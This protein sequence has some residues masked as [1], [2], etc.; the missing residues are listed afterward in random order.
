MRDRLKIIAFSLTGGKNTIKG[1]WKL[2]ST[3]ISIMS[4]IFAFSVLL[5]DLLGFDKAEMLCKH[6]W[7]CLLLAGIL[8]SLIMNREKVS[9]KGT[10]EGDDLQ[11][12]IEVTDLFHVNASSYVIPTNTFFRT[13]MEGEY[14]SP[15]SVQGAFQLKFFKNNREELDQLILDS[16]LQ[17]G[18]VGE[19]SKDIYG[20]VKK[21]PIGTVAKVDHKDK[22]FYFVAINDLSIY[23][24][25]ENQSYQNIDFA[26]KGLFET[27]K[28]LG[29]CDD[30]AMPLIG[31]GKAAIREATIEKVAKDTVDRFLISKEKITRKLTICINPKDFLDEKVDLKRIGKYVDYR[32]NFR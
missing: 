27:I 7:Y 25:P 4:S 3:T 17:Q 14:I 19:Q 23:G 29:H 11:I 15:R 10:L 31:T 21:Y 30:L 5:K 1:M 22:H 6:Y 26:F 20:A 2:I 8:A 16:L 13:V 28:K 32:C 24:K 18:I 9:Y 12:V